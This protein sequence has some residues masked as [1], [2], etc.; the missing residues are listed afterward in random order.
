MGV[1][2]RAV[3]P[4]CGYEKEL[5]T[6]AGLRGINVDAIAQ[7][8]PPE[9]VSEF[10]ELKE[11]GKVKEY[12]LEH[13]PTVCH[14]CKELMTVPFFH[15]ETA[16]GETKKYVTACYTCMKP[17]EPINENDVPCPKCG[18]KMEFMPAGLW[19]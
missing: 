14:E 9:V 19:D 4:A 12:L 2:I 10:K 17:T 7:I 8:F 15:Y 11:Q 1:I 16:E 3:C 18:H 5:H 13:I 6:G